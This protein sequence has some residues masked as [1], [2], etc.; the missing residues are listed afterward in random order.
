MEA[1]FFLSMMRAVFLPAAAALV[2]LLA[3]TAGMPQPVAHGY[4]AALAS[5]LLWLTLRCVLQ[6][7]PPALLKRWM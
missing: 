3:P 4:V 7:D 2:L 1:R 5:V 6:N